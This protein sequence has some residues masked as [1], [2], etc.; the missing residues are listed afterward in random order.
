MCDIL[1][2]QVARIAAMGFGEA[3]TL[4]HA[5]RA[6]LFKGSW[7]AEVD[8][9]KSLL[10]PSPCLPLDGG[11]DGGGSARSKRRGRGGV[12]DVIDESSS[13]LPAAER[14]VNSAPPVTIPCVFSRHST[15]KAR[16]DG[17]RYEI[18]NA[19]GAASPAQKQFESLR[20]S[21]KPR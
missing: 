14:D 2:T 8:S 7:F 15:P 3:G 21:R 18:G 6:A 5:E 16:R 17:D 19:R 10:Q 12:V 20:S 9:A 11:E 13:S 4:S 1:I